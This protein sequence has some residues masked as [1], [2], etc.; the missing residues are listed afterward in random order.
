MNGAGELV[1]FLA[2]SHRSID[3]AVQRPGGGVTHAELTLHPQRRQTGLGLADQIDGQD[4]GGQRQIGVFKQ[5]ARGQQGLMPAANALEQTPGAVTNHVVRGAAAE[6]A[7]EAVGPA[8]GLQR[9]CAV[10][11]GAEMR[12]VS[13]QVVF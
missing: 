2:S 12:H 10:R 5:A 8:G 1:H 13:N 11:L 6:W 4:P 9:R 3:L 7:A